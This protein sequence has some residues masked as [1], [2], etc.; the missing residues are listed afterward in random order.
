MTNTENF[1]LSHGDYGFV[2]ISPEEATKRKLEVLYDVHPDNESQ[3]RAL[4][5]FTGTGI[6]GTAPIKDQA[7]RALADT[8][9]QPAKL[10]QITHL[11]E[12]LAENR[13][14]E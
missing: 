2:T 11:I 10:S 8:G 13:L 5:E 7:E 12:S 4:F 14:E 6:S 9:R 3:G 1:S